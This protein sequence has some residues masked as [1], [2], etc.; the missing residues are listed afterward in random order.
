[1]SDDDKRKLIGMA[2]QA[3]ATDHPDA[4]WHEDSSDDIVTAATDGGASID[5]RGQ[6]Q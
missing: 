5:A 4:A 1:M 3:V 6:G 2:K